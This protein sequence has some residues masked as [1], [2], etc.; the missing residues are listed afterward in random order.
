MIGEETKRQILEKEIAYRM[1][2]LLQ[3]VAVRMPLV[4]L[5]TLSMKK[6]CD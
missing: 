3:S 1:P 2:L 5:L 6:V 4:C